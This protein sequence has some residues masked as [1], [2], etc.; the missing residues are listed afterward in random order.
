MGVGG[1]RII[2]LTLVGG[3][4]NLSHTTQLGITR[5]QGTKVQTTRDPESY[6]QKTPPTPPTPPQDL[7]LEGMGV[8]NDKSY[9]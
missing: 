2:S 9:L 4:I 1:G 5:Q 6:P 3:C 8:A 7:C